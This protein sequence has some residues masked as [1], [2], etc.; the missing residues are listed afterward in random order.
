MFQDSANNEVE[1]KVLL[2]DRNICVVTIHRND[3][4]DTVYNVSKIMYSLFLKT[5]IFDTEFNK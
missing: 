2:P 3:T 5:W 4:T 1:L